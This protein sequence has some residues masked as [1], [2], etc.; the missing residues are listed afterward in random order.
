MA[1]KDDQKTDDEPTGKETLDEKVSNISE[2]GG[3]SDHTGYLTVAAI[4]SGHFSMLFKVYFDS[5]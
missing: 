3:V 2:V 1:E 5:T 4:D